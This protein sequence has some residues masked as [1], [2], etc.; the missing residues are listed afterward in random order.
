[1][2][3]IISA[4]LTAAVSVSVIVLPVS[5]ASSAWQSENEMKS[6]LSGLDIM[7][8]DDYGNF[9]LDSYVTRAEMAKIAI[10]SS[11]YKN[12]VALGLKFSP[13]S[14]VKGS[15]WGAPYI[16]AA[17]S[18]GIVE[19]Y[20]DGTFRPNGTVKYEEAITMMLKVLGYTNDDFGASYPYGQV[21]MAQNLRMTEGMDAS[22]GEPLTRRQVG[23]LVCNSLDTSMNNSSQDLI[24]VHDCEI[25][26]DITV[27]ADS[28]EDFTLSS[29]EI[30]TSEGKYR[31]RDNFN[32][33]YIGASGDMVIK[34]GKYFVAFSPDGRTSSDRYVVYSTL[35][36]AI[37][38]YREG[39]NNNIVELSISGTTSCYKDGKASTYS[40][41]SS[42]MEMGDT[43]RIRYKE[44]GEIDY[45]SYSESSI[46]GPIKV[47]SSSWIS[48]F[49]TN[50]STKIMRDGIRSG[51]GDIETNDIIYYSGTLNMILAY[52]KKITGVYESA[53]PSKDMP[54]SVTVSGVTY[55]V[56]GAEAFNDLSSSGSAAYGDTVTLLMGRDGKSVAGVAGGNTASGETLVGY[57]IESGRKQF[58][59]SDGTKYES[60][61]ITAVTPDGVQ[62]T[63]PTDYDRKS[64]VNTVS[65]ISVK[66]GRATLG[67]IS[68]SSKLSGAVS[69]A[70]M[71]I[72]GKR[73][74]ENIQIIDVAKNAYSNAVLYCKT[75][76]QR[77]DG[78]TLSTGMIKYYD[79]NSNGEINK[80]ILQNV[81]GDMYSY[82]I[83]TGYDKKSGVY[84][85][86]A[87][88][89]SYSTVNVGGL[90]VGDTIKFA[91]DTEG[92][93]YA[94]R[95]KSYSG[96]IDSINGAEAVI[97]NKTY[98]ISDKVQ[99]YIKRDTKYFISSINDITDGN[100]RYTCYYD[101]PEAEGGRIRVIIAQ[102]K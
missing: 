5:A 48:S 100:Y 91:L 19:G 87:N 18:A 38:C 84:T 40:A 88:G 58:T 99:A 96:A 46:E 28:R 12:T 76:M 69:R 90:T 47:T 64:S 23:L 44:N 67:A 3:K 102:S 101:K 68:G 93:K 49:D 61:Y 56:E 77:L 52:S 8:G 30:S 54:Q 63:Y 86:T 14:D 55:Q 1:M 36:D 75:Y 53:S 70:N 71:T 42:Q 35:N 13:F 39:D 17:V 27:I 60:Y 89:G 57:V 81:T 50:S 9:N 82:G 85:I 45:I 72:G 24:S 20:I 32:S 31:I 22:I 94:E 7:V 33:D 97:N 43:V 37:L 26:E 98:R 29:D 11:S 6:L 2:K 34:D 79:T 59:N 16:Q 74:A 80:L 25:K 21:G 83:V 4:I 92:I 15:F 78:M 10:A 73:V 65:R 62:Y 66:D 41:L 95:L 51:E